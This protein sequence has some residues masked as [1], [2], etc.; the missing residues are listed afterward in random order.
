MRARSL[1]LAIA[2]S[3]AAAAPAGAWVPEKTPRRQVESSVRQTLSFPAALGTVPGV[4]VRRGGVDL[5]AMNADRPFEPAS[6]MKLATTTAA[7]DPFGADY[8]FGPR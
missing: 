8:A 3:L 7:L 2:L 4:L 5:F 6:L 1:P